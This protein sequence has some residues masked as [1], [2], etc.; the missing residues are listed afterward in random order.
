[1][2]K[3]RRCRFFVL[4]KTRKKNL[5]LLL[6]STSLVL[7]LVLQALWLHSVYQQQSRGFERETRGLLRT[8]VFEMHDSLVQ[9]NLQP[10]M[11]DSG[12]I[13]ISR[14]FVADTIKND[15]IRRAPDPTASVRIYVANGSSDT[16]ARLVSPII[17]GIRGNPQVRQFSLRLGG[18]SLR[19]ESVSVEYKKRLAA[20]GIHLPFELTCIAR[21]VSFPPPNEAAFADLVMTPQ[22][23]Y[24]VQFQG[25]TWLM[26]QKIAPQIL[27]SVFLTALTLISFVMLYRALRTQQR[28]ME[29][30]NDFISNMTH[31]LK[32]P[33]ATVSVALEALTSF[34]ALDNPKRTHEYL[35]IAKN[36]LN[37][38]ALLTDKVLRASAFEKEG[39]DFE[40][41]PVEFKEV[42]QQVLASMKLIFEK[43]NARVSFEMEGHSFGVVGS[44]THLTNVIFN[45]VDNALKYSEGEPVLAIR[46]TEQPAAVLITVA[47]QGMG[48][49][50][51][52]QNK[53]FEQFFRVPTGNVHT[54]KGYG[55]GLHYVASVVR[56]HNG[57][58]TLQSAAGKGTTFTITLPKH[59]TP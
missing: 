53:I 54:R 14:S 56:S 37:R 4:M 16:L 34:N 12:R 28:L 7:L 20:L 9:R 29:L 33:L 10:L 40:P 57:T 18:D 22:G 30:K 25:L 44:N 52:Y 2:A 24:R 36:E 50:T 47:D 15:W 46:L 6:I 49:P 39:I 23:G 35:E 43:R 58:I 31:E 59:S 41:E 48:I 8:T 11:G 32:T 17:A 38:L 26:L 42:V 51:E 27:F 19:T 45:L 21:E 55:L 5:A 3:R 1:M 13:T